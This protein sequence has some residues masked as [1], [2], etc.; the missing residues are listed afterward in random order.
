[1][2]ADEFLRCS[3]GE[4][5]ICRR[6]IFK[7]DISRTKAYLINI[8]QFAK[9]GSIY[10]SKVLLH[11]QKKGLNIKNYSFVFEKLPLKMSV[12]DTHGIPLD[13]FFKDKEYEVIMEEDDEEEKDKGN[14]EERKPR[15]PERVIRDVLYKLKKWRALHEKC[16]WSLVNAAKEVGVKKKTL[17][18]YYFA[19]RV[20]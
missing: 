3:L 9:D 14:E 6:F 1:M 12:G 15:E 4:G 7:N 19:I 11:L 18:D 13:P 10:L 17:D 16:S 5:K 20:G 2:M 8:C